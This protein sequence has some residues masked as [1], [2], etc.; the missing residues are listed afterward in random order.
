MLAGI[1]VELLHDYA[2]DYMQ[3]PRSRYCGYPVIV[4]RDSLY[5]CLVVV[6]GRY[7]YANSSIIFTRLV[8]PLNCREPWHRT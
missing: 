6:F 7:G 8:R 2:S 1:I 5:G 3:L 4:C